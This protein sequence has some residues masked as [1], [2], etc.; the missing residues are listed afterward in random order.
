[1]IVGA[2]LC[3]RP[4]L[5]HMKTLLIYATNSG[6]TI[7]VSNY[8]SEEFSK[9]GKEISTK[10]AREVDP[11]EFEN[12]DLIIFGSPT[13]DEGNVH[14]SFLRLMEKSEGKTFPNKK[15]A[16]FGLGDNS[17]R[18]FCGSADHLKDFVTKL[19]GNVIADPL[20]INNFYF[21]QQEELTKIT[22]WSQ[23][24]LTSLA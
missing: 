2:I 14:D 17:Y 18:H 16:V 22:D 21:N 4:I 7:E 24:I 3:N 5:K 23:K 6:S 1:M 15:F 8:I 12:Y 20:K 13:Y 11:A 19:G 9:K 10:D